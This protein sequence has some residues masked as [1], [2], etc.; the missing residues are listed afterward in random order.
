[1]KILLVDD[2]KRFGMLLSKRLALRGIDADY[3][4]SGEEAV[5]KVTDH[6]YDV[7]VLDVKMPGIGGIALERR[8]RLLAPDMKTIFLTGHGF[9][10]GSIES[11]HYLSK[12]I[13]IENLLEELKKIMGK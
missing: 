5:A 1:M 6:H 7:A 10:I 13:T 4:N 3:V 9:E 11:E 2:E 8:L 12:P